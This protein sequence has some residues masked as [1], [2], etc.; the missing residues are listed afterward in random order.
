MGT[1]KGTVTHQ[2][3]LLRVTGVGEGDGVETRDGVTHY[4]CYHQQFEYTLGQV[5]LKGKK[6]VKN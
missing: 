1:L 2:G 4:Q 5:D 3:M 6:I